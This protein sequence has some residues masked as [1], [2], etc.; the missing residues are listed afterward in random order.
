MVPER[1]RQ[2]PLERLRQGPTRVSNHALVQALHRVD[3]IRLFEAEHID[4]SL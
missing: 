3:A 4:L 1:Q 2:T